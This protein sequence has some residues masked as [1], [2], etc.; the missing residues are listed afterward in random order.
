MPLEETQS[1]SDISLHLLIFD[2]KVCQIGMGFRRKEEE[3]QKKKGFQSRFWVKGT[4]Q[5]A[6]NRRIAFVFKY[7][8]K[9]FFTG[10]Q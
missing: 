5:F 1:H 3:E 4:Q 9:N 2:K 7:W 8:N 6:L 10:P